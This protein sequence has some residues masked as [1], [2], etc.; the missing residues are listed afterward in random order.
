[1]R[2]HD[3]VLVILERKEDPLTPLAI[4]WSYQSLI[5]EMAEFKD[6]KV[7]VK[8]EEFNLNLIHDEFYRD[9]RRKNYGD[10]AKGL[11]Q[12]MEEFTSKQKQGHKLDNFEDMQRAL[13]QMPE[14]RQ[15]AANLKKHHVIVKEITQQVNSRN[16]LEVSGLE[17]DILSKNSMKEHFREA[18][19]MLND[20]KVRDYDKLRIASM[21]CVKYE[22]TSQASG[23]LSVLRDNVEDPQDYEAMVKK[24]LQKCGKQRRVVDKGGPSNLGNT[25]KKF[26]SDIFG[27]RQ[28]QCTSSYHTLLS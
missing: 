23:M 15:T 2:Q 25:A 28:V 9:F 17:Q 5:S 7:S 14:H 10:L 27:V 24:L 20:P 13:H 16:L 8:S 26:Y 6:N 4:D 1:M 19:A 18:Q 21:F 3:S 11:N 12:R 22:G